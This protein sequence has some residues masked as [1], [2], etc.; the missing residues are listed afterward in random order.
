MNIVLIGMRGSGK[1]AVAKLL[2]TKIGFGMVE[3]DDLIEKGVSERIAD[4]VRKNGW[5][6]FRN[7]EFRVIKNVAKLDKSIVSTGGGVVEN[8]ENI[9]NLKHNGFVI[10]LKAD[11]KTLNNRIRTDKSRPFLTDTDS[12]AKDLQSVLRKRKDL[13][14]NIADLTVFVDNKSVLE[15]TSEIVNAL[16]SKQII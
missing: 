8:R 3:T 1:S 12:M 2:S 10:Y 4:I 7:L 16:K 5:K 11:L 13:Y 15:I 9:V 6:E 14:E